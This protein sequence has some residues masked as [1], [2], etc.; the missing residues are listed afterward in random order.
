MAR[1]TASMVASDHGIFI[2]GILVPRYIYPR[3][4]WYQGMFILGVLVPRYIYQ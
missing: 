3:Y 2:L 4:I 1:N